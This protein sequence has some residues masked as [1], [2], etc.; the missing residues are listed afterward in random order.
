[1][2]GD[3]FERFGQM[4]SGASKSLQRLKSRQMSKYGLTG[5]HTICLRQLYENPLGL[6]KSEIADNCDIDKAQITRIVKELMEKQYVCADTT[7]K[8]YNRK[9][10]LTEQ[11]RNITD[12]INDIVD[13]IVRYVNMEIPK[14]DIEQFYSVF[15]QINEKLKKSE[16]NIEKGLI[17]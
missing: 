17:L 13:S 10:F 14:E 16:D 11:G 4:V 8:A 2:E 5:T 1:M 15:E 7:K 12:E 9:F 6:T 3:S